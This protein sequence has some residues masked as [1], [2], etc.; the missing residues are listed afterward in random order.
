MKHVRR[1]L[2]L[3]SRCREP[4]FLFETVYKMA[5]AALFVPGFSACFTLLTRMTG[6]R[7]LTAENLRSFVLHP[8]TLLFFAL[9]LAVLACYFLIDIGV[10]L[11]LLDQAAQGKPCGILHALR[12]T[13][14]AARRGFAPGSL[15]ML[16][17]L[18]LLALF[19]HMG[20]AA[21]LIATIRIPVPV[22]AFLLKNPLYLGLLAA[23]L[24]ALTLWMVLWLSV[25]HWHLNGGLSFRQ[26]IQKSMALSRSFG[27]QSLAG[28]L[29]VQ[30]GFI[31]IYGVAALVGIV[32]LRAISASLAR[33]FLTS[34]VLT[35][36]ISALLAVSILSIPITYA[37]IYALLERQCAARNMPMA[38]A[39]PEASLLSP[40]KRRLR[41]V[42]GLL[43]FLTA[44]AACVFIFYRYQ[45]RH[46]NLDIEYLRA[47]EITAHRGASA[48]YPENTMAAFEGA[49]AQGADWIELDVRMS[50]DGEIFC[51]HDA[52]FTRTTGTSGRAW[53][54]DW[55]EISRL[56][57]GSRFDQAFAGEGL[58][59]LRDAIAFAQDRHIRLNIE[60]K[61]SAQDTGLEE[62]VAALIREAG[63]EDD[64]VVTCQ[65]YFALEKIK[66]IAPE[67]TT[68]YVM[69]MIYG[70]L[71][72]FAAADHFS[73][74]YH[75]ITR[76][77]VSRLHSAGKQ[78]YAWTVDRRD[79]MER[80]IDLEV[81]NII[82]NNVTLARQCVSNDAASDIVQAILEEIG[83]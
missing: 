53:E 15:L 9:L 79:I 83:E 44:L 69:S 8:L 76:A 30:A 72:Q 55:V 1:T 75:F 4:L 68:V 71:N 51:M 62:G 56:D 34:H 14:R 28:I 81:D 23:V 45:R 61:P 49:W 70:D 48:D 26:S 5:G 46:Y 60:L 39:L 32:L 6:H 22:S 16:L 54:K 17:Y 66:Q 11:C 57:A 59:L 80:M 67:L 47:T 12:H 35:F 50:R 37:T 25:P 21:A 20:T 10:V 73:V 77:M 63:F 43:A 19:L 58:P 31:L 2:Q 27:L 42:I 38:H 52:S 65:R 41:R 18:P 74:S 24:L 82:T 7:Y 40:R 36:L 78:I 33:S 13:L 64:C 3:L 29:L